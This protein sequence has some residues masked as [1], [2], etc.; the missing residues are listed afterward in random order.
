MDKKRG[1]GCIMNNEYLKMYGDCSNQFVNLQLI[2]FD[3]AD[4]KYLV[5]W[6]INENDYSNDQDFYTYKDEALEAFNEMKNKI[7]EVA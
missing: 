4:K 6:Y 1:G 5:E 2:E 3:K 7:K